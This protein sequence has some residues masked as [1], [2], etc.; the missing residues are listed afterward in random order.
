MAKKLQKKTCK[1]SSFFPF[2]HYLIHNIDN[3]LQI[4][5]KK[6]LNF[7]LDVFVIKTYDFFK[8]YNHTIDGIYCYFL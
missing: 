1:S 8:I 6:L 3:V 5:N 4:L 2:S 7:E